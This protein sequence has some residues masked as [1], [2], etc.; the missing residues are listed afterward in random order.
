MNMKYIPGGSDGKNSDKM[1]ETKFMNLK[2]PYHSLN[3]LNREW[4][5]NCYPLF[6]LKIGE[7]YSKLIF[8][9]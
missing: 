6:H 3:Q 5:K 7:N 8:D 9:W 1:N 4:G 2:N